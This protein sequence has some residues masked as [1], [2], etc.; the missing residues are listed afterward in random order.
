M[1][2]I[3]A[4]GYGN[5]MDKKGRKQ[6]YEIQKIKGEEVDRKKVK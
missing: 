6:W 5:R 1:L 4:G 2:P 3:L